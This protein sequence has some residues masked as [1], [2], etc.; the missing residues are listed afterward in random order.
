M[1]L[2][3]AF[4]V[5][6]GMAQATE[7]IDLREKTSLRLAYGSCNGWRNRTSKI[8]DQV[9]REE[10]DIW[11]WL[12]DSAY[13]DRRLVTEKLQGDP[14]RSQLTEEEVGYIESRFNASKGDAHYQRLVDSGTRVLGVWDDHDYGMGNGDVTF[15]GKDQVRRVFLDFIGEPEGSLRRNITH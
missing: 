6:S 13:T 5:L 7:V 8:F 1:N 14:S 2:L 11:L 9:V 12:G 15:K 4:I 3:W 10:P